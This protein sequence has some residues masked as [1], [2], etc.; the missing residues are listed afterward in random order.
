M[1]VSGA[2][3]PWKQRV[4]LGGACLVAALAQDVVRTCPLL[5]SCGVIQALCQVCALAAFNI[6]L[7]LL[8]PLL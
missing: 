1:C 8:T 4:Q 2:T 3:V 7:I 6:A 5:R